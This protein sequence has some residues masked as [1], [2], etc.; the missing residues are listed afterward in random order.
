MR[1]VLDAIQLCN[2]DISLHSSSIIVWN[3]LFAI[4]KECFGL[5]DMGRGSRRNFSLNSAK[6]PRV[7]IYYIGM[8]QVTTGMTNFGETRVAETTKYIIYK[9]QAR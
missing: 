4:Q 3:T 7:E 9:L 2:C 6:H 1:L 5:G 8:I